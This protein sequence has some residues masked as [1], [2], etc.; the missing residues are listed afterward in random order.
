[1]S[2]IAPLATASAA[3]P[4]L[5]LFT[6]GHKKGGH[7]GSAK[8]VAAS[9]TAQGPATTQSLL[10]SVLESIEQVIG[11]SV[12]APQAASSPATAPANLSQGAQ[13]VPSGGNQTVGG[14]GANVNLRV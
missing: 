8:D 11:I 7:A 3:S 10:S 9:S 13:S 1:M 12:T 5:N 2:L 6:H 14:I 4:T